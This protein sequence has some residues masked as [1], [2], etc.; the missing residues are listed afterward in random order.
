MNV[1]SGVLTQGSQCLNLN[2]FIQG[3]IDMK[4]VIQNIR[5]GENQ[6]NRVKIKKYYRES[7]GKEYSAY[8][9]TKEN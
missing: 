5:D 6:T 7:T 1:C 9:K 4:E 2:I 3:I 8:N